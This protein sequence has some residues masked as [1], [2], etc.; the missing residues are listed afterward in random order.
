MEQRRLIL[1]RDLAKAICAA[2]ELP[3]ETVARIVIDIPVDDIVRVYMERLGD[4]RLLHVNWPPLQE[5]MEVVELRPKEG[6]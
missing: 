2:L 4:D 5:G 3:Y 6:G 1:G